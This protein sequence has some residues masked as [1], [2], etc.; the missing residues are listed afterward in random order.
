MGTKIGRFDEIRCGES[1]CQHNSQIL[2]YLG[3]S[4]VEH[5]SLTRV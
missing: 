1:S 5:L 2:G 4:V 3:V